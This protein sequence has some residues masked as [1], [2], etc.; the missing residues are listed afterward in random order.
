MNPGIVLLLGFLLL[1]ALRVPIAFAL[2]LVSGLYFVIDPRLGA[3]GI[4]ERFILGVD[5]FVLLAVPFFIFAAVLMN[6]ARITE[7][8]LRLTRAI[9][10]PL[11]GGLG[12]VN[13]GVS[14]AFAGVSGSAQ[15]DTAGIGSVLIPEMKKRG[16][17]VEFTV[18]ITATSSV[19]GAI[20]PPSILM[21]L[22]GSLTGTSIKGL[23]LGGILPGF[24]IG[25]GLLAYVY[26]VSR[27]YGYPKEPRISLR[28]AARAALDSALALGIPLLVIGGI[29]VGLVTAT[30]AAVLAVLYAL[31]LG[32]VV[33][34]TLNLRNIAVALRDTVHLTAL[35]MFAVGAASAV[36]FL[37]A[38]YRV[39][40]VVSELFDGIPA[41]W[42][43]GAIVLVWFVLG[44]FLDSFPAMVIMVPVF[45]PLVASAGIDPIQYGVVSV[46]TLAL[47]LATPP[48]GLCLLLASA[49]GGVP[50]ARVLRAL[51]GPLAVM[52]G[53]LGLAIFV[54]E[55]VLF[56]PSL[57]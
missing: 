23:F 2:I 17:P 40:F 46:M 36:G 22:W 20:I 21:I 7:R 18:A 25:V 51:V 37:L 24:G 50:V 47:G 53:V 11:T 16:Y 48:F 9:V 30:E 10:G 38:Y 56:V 35:S 39:P 4:A 6:E 45:A 3:W 34:R 33:Y 12:M 27:R 41:F 54:P 49:I 29:V 52:L 26:A 8:L 14:M 43:L 19:M 55:F 32:C 15:A 5:S 42:L 31:F 57:F 44:M 28:E 13:V 1:M